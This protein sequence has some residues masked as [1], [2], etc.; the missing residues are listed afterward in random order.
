MNSLGLYT[1]LHMRNQSLNSMEANFGRA[2]PHYY[3]IPTGVDNREVR[4]NRSRKLVDA[5]NT[6]LR[7]LTE[8]DALAAELQPPD[9]QGLAARR[10]QGL[11]GRTVTLK[12]KFNDFEIVTRSRSGVRS[13]IE[14]EGL[15][16]S[17]KLGSRQS[18]T[19]APRLCRAR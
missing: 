1:G 18:L 11:A 3:W 17:V 2:G 10:R 19:C 6:F 8:F 4:A 9:R 15:A 7:D 14:L 13:G 5:E 16:I 12:M